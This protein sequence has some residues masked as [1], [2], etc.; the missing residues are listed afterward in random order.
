M[1]KTEAPV[2]YPDDPKPG[3][4][5]VHAR[6]GA[7]RSEYEGDLRLLCAFVELVIPREGLPM[8]MANVM[9]RDI[10]TRSRTGRF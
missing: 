7:A 5:E 9:S 8:S 3:L 1:F 2:K 4:L 10:T 6:I